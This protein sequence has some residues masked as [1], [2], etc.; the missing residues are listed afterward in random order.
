V[1]V[2]DHSHYIGCCR[3]MVA[4][5]RGLRKVLIMAGVMPLQ[6][7]LCVATGLAGCRTL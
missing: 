2:S 6:F 3:F 5:R 7:L 1:C 4:V